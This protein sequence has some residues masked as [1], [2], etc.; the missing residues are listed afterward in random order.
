MPSLAA[1]NPAPDPAILFVLNNAVFTREFSV[2]EGALV[3]ASVDPAH[4]V[5][6]TSVTVH[7]LQAHTATA[8][9]H[10]HTNIHHSK[11]VPRL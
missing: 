4:M 8:P 6:D 9:K 1:G 10:L 3:G 11:T 5:F 2:T 7:V